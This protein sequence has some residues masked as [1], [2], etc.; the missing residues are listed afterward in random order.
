MNLGLA[1]F[2][3]SGIGLL[4]GVLLGTTVEPV[5]S[6]IIGALASGLAVLLGLNDEHF[7]NAKAIRIG[8]FG[9][10]CIVGA[11][12]GIYVRAHELLSP[13]QPTMA[14]QKADYIK[15]GFS[16]REALDFIAFERLGIKN[17]AWEV[18]EAAEA[19][20]EQRRKGKTSQ[21]FGAKVNLD[22]C[23]EL[24]STNVGMSL[25]DAVGNYVIAGGVWKSLAESVRNE[26]GDPHGVLVLLAA[27]DAF[28]ASDSKGTK[29]IDD[30][31]CER[32]GESGSDYATAREQM[33][34]LGGFWKRLSNG[35]DSI[36]MDDEKKLNGMR[37]V[38]ENLCRKEQ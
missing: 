26:I 15:L 10:A 22:K 17:P 31:E 14:E 13:V 35:I 9:I 37:V 19:A 30:K 36:D 18:S 11:Y 33:S 28:C 25:R 6:V 29:R 21:L 38:R 12:A 2:S 5:V 7:G 1:W 34:A 3:G 23:G 16:E 8:S 32:L 4:V 20:A 24:E 27:R